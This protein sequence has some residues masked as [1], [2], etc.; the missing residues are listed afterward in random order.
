[1]A[2]DNSVRRVVYLED[3]E[4][5]AA[6]RTATKEVVSV[7]VTEHTTDGATVSEADALTTVTEKKTATGATKRQQSLNDMF[8]KKS[9]SS[10]SSSSS[11]ARARPVQKRARTDTPSLNSIPF[12]LK[13]YQDSLSD[14]ERTLLTLECETLGK[15]W[16]VRN[17][18]TIIAMQTH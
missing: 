5:K 4:V 13:E 3:L 15:S 12:S 1:M 6:K 9:S 10:S 16:S 18:L 14:E 8:P 11:G 7:T 17:A 2:S